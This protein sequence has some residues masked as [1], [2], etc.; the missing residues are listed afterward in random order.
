MRGMAHILRMRSGNPVAF[1]SSIGCMYMGGSP[2][3]PHHPYRCRS[4][5]LTGT[6]LQWCL[7]AATRAKSM[8]RAVAMHD[9]A[10]HHTVL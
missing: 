8:R 10:E 6:M 2:S 9:T 5:Q 7:H 4:S 3:M 1:P